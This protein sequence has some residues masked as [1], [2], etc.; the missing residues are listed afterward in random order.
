MLLG[1]FQMMCLPVPGGGTGAAPPKPPAGGAQRAVRCLC[2]S[3]PLAV[4]VSAAPATA[5]LRPAAERASS[6]GPAD[7]SSV[8]RQLRSAVRW[9]QVLLTGCPRMRLTLG[10]ASPGLSCRSSW[11]Q[12]ARLL[13]SSFRR[14]LHGTGLCAACG[15][16]CSWAA[17]TCR[18]CAHSTTGMG[19]CT[20]R[21]MT[22]WPGSPRS[23]GASARCRAAS[24][25]Q[26]RRASPSWP[27]KCWP[28]RAGGLHLGRPPLPLCRARLA[29]CR[30]CSRGDAL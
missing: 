21:L 22:R 30:R 7:A 12:L 13:P 6:R 9:T 17:T 19:Q 23:T 18:L 27:M 24:P 5:A 20:W 10:L 3:Q 25:V 29:A 16:P 1:A 28:Q 26:W 8:P 14:L 11:R 2:A 4:P 15:V